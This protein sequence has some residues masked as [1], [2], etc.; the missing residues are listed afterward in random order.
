MIVAAAIP[1][2]TAHGTAVTT[3]QIA[4]AAGIGEA[5]IFRVFAGKDEVLDACVAETLDPGQVVRELALISL[6]DPLATRLMQAAEALR[7]HLDRMSAVVGALYA[8]GHRRDP[9]PQRPEPGARETSLSAIRE[10]LAD[11]IEPDRESLWLQPESLAGIFLGLLVTH[12]QP[13]AVEDLVEVVLHGALAQPD[14][15]HST[16]DGG[17]RPAAPA[18]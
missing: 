8:S 1:L 6:D 2:V 13:A 7:A 18:T 4:R 10:S 3:A 11:L 5:T 17:R 16:V 14:D 15:R 12:R 9:T